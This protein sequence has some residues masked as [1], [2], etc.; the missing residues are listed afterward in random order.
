MA[1]E[2]PRSVLRRLKCLWGLGWDFGKRSVGAF[3]R[4]LYRSE[5]VVVW[6]CMDVRC[7]KRHLLWISAKSSLLVWTAVKFCQQDLLT[8]SNTMVGLFIRLAFCLQCYCKI[9]QVNEG[10]EATSFDKV[11]AHQ[12][13][14][15]Q[16]ISDKIQVKQTTGLG[17][18]LFFLFVDLFGKLETLWHDR[19]SFFSWVVS[20]DG[21]S[22]QHSCR[23]LVKL[24][25]YSPKIQS[26]PMP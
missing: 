21:W 19:F 2:V 3:G 16:R 17:S 14:K 9:W 12:M 20:G 11:Q 1:G 7:G 8:S 15:K 25:V 6:C 23:N 5:R 13:A 22:C 10:G 18:I 4:C 26:H 24:S